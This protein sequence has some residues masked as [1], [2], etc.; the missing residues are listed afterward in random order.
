MVNYGDLVLN[1][2]NLA[3]VQED[4]SPQFEVKRI[5]NKQNLEHQQAADPS[6][7]EDI[8]EHKEENVAGLG[9]AFGRGTPVANSLEK[10]ILNRNEIEAANADAANSQNRINTYNAQSLEF[11]KLKKGYLNGQPV[12]GN[13]TEGS[14]PG[15]VSLLKQINMVEASGK[16]IQK[17]NDSRYVGMYQ[18]RYEPGDIGYAW[19]KKNGYTSQQ[20]LASPALQ[21]RMMSDQLK[22]YRSSFSKRG[23]KSTPYTLYMAHNQGV[24]GASA[25]LSGRLTKKIR[26]NMVNQ[27]IGGKSTDSD[28]VLIQKYH[29]KF[30]KRFV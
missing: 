30:R 1:Y 25:I 26:M 20:I 14:D 13:Y 15:D 2:G 17:P 28:Y 18:Q 6:M 10:F 11:E 3:P 29:N 22:G 5:A 7:I 4:Y 23:I 9:G 24:G 16:N 21:N 8:N 19:A 12:A 27:N